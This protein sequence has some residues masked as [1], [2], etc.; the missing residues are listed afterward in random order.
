MKSSERVLSSKF[1]QKVFI[2]YFSLFAILVLLFAA[3]SSSWSAFVA[4]RRIE[5]ACEKALS[6]VNQAIVSQM[7]NMSIF[8]DEIKRLKVNLCIN[9]GSCSYICPAKRELAQKMQLAKKVAGNRLPEKSS[10]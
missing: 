4:R 1:A 10:S 5:D 9:C 8:S 3:V 2:S 7:D 6:G